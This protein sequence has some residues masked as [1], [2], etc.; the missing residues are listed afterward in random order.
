MI[1]SED[2]VHKSTIVGCSI[3][4]THTKIPRHSPS[5]AQVVKRRSDVREV[6]SSSSYNNKI[7]KRCNAK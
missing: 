1:S 6:S 7:L 4:N 2:Y 5:L 3:Q